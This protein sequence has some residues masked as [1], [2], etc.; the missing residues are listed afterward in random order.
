MHAFDALYRC[1]S[2]EDRHCENGGMQVSSGSV[3]NCDFR[4]L[5]NVT[6]EKFGVLDILFLN[7]GQSAPLEFDAI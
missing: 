1:D 6:I 5:I 2:S 4:N 3:V 7:A